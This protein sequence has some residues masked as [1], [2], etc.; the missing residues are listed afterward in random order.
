MP[1]SKFGGEIEY[2]KIIERDNKKYLKSKENGL[3][4]F[5]FSYEKDIPET[6]I[7][8]IFTNESKLIEQI[9]KI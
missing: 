1:I 2:K 3:K 5:Y 6:Y 7:D 8:T 4:I 9:K